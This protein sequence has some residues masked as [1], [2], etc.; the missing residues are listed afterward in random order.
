MISILIMKPSPQGCGRI[1]SL[2]RCLKVCP[3]TM[4]GGSFG[5]A[6]IL[7]YDFEL[8]E[9]IF[10][11]MK[12]RGGADGCLLIVLQQCARLPNEVNT[13]LPSGYR[14]IFG[15][16]SRSPR[17]VGLVPVFL[18]STARDVPDSIG[19]QSGTSPIARK[20][21]NPP[22]WRRSWV[23]YFVQFFVQLWAN[24]LSGCLLK[25]INH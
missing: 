18:E 7:F 8:V 14:L 11:R 6:V 17:S 22:F 1:L 15:S 12:S 2:C 10:S 4:L 23:Q 9:I 21:G 3:L 20:N 5:I 25:L 19:N 16:S 13:H 24:Y